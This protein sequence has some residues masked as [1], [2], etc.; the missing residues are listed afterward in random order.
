MKHV[1]RTLTLLSCIL[2][3]GCDDSA[4]IWS[5]Q[6]KSP[7]G[8]LV[9]TAETVQNAGPG[10]GYVGTSV[11]LKQSNI[12]QEP[13]LVLGFS[14]ESAYPSGV[15]ALQLHWQSSSKLD[16]TYKPGATIDFQAIK[17]LGVDITV[18]QE[19]SH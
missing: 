12:K 6:V 17:A 18:H 2:F 9:A 5:A 13:L 8:N 11:Y 10:T 19:S 4:T 7:N 15:T 14:N 3:A 1:A 16:V